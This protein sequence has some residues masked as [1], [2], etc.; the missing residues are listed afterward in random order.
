MS[1]E[2]LLEVKNLNVYYRVYEGLM[3]VL[4][5]VSFSLV[6]GERL[7]LVGETG[8]GKTTTFR[9]LLRVLDSNASSKGDILYKGCNVNK[10]SQT[11]LLNTRRTEM[12]MIFQ[13]PTSSLN[14]VF[15]VGEQ[16]SSVIRANLQAKRINYSEN[17]VKDIALKALSDVLL[18]DPERIF[19]AYPFQLSGGM[20]Q[21]ICI[22]MSVA[23]D[24]KLL[25]ADEPGTS[26]D[27]TI[28]AQILGLLNNLVKTTGMSVILA[29]HS[30]GVVR[31]TTDRVCIMYGG[32]IVEIGPTRSLFANPS[33]PYT[34]ALLA[35]VPKLTGEGIAEGIPGEMV[36][37]LNPPKGCRFQPRC[38]FCNEDCNRT[39]PKLT[40]YEDDHYVAC[41]KADL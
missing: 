14:P 37:Y 30:L 5:D 8:C 21:R 25:L 34:R 19:D 13:D 40:L 2:V 1:S 17:D 28:Q 39:K 36:S 22:A 12:S 23:T 4:D 11:E 38:S 18:P 27:V 20:R 10:M 26:L 35:C 24:R 9:A 31:E 29:T 41:H 32:E 15:T 33:H 16:I 6:E 3:H 7:G